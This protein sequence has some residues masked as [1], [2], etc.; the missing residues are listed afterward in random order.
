M[1]TDPALFTHPFVLLLAAQ[2]VFGFGFST[3]LIMPTYLAKA[4]QASPS[5]IGL[6]TSIFG[7]SGMIFMPLVGD[8]AD[9]TRRLPWAM[10]GAGICAVASLGFVWVDEIGSL[11]YLLR[12]LHGFGNA[13]EF[14]AAGALTIDLVP[15]KRLGQGL[16]FFGV[17][18]LSTNAIAPAMA[19]AIADRWDWD[20]AFAV[21]ALAAVLG[22]LLL[23]RVEEPEREHSHAPTTSIFKVAF[24]GRSLWFSTVIALA[25][26]GFA[27]LFTFVQPY[28]LDLG[29]NRVS[30]F[31]LGYTATAV[32]VRI[33][34]GDLGDRIGLARVGMAAIALYGVP[35]AL[36]A[37]LQL[38]W[39]PWIGAIFGLAH[40]AL[41]PTLN[42]FIVEPVPKNERAKVLALFMASFNAGWSIGSVILG[43]I[44]EVAGYPTVFWTA[45]AAVGA[46]ALLFLSSAEVRRAIAKGPSSA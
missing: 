13:L 18:M 41:F 31:F 21:A 15:T 32:G 5:Q 12:L 40:G 29:A 27:S 7:I 33:F 44:A 28:A 34:F 19:E 6:V 26:V 10:T 1:R 17:A 46:A 16:G 23:S 24:T 20:T 39:L 45:T 9:R 30:G 25:G 36:S 4:L 3:F 8:W 38:S 43:V 2:A 37:D 22:L 42:A 35:I 14:V 11:V